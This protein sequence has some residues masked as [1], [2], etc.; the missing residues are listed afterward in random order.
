MGK[1]DDLIAAVGRAAPDPK[2]IRA[3]HG[4]PYDFDRFDASKIGSGEGAQAYGHGLYFAGEEGVAQYYRNKLA[5]QAPFESPD[6]VAAEYLKVWG[7]PS[8]VDWS[9]RKSP[10]L[11]LDKLRK[12][13]ADPGSYGYDA[14]QGKMLREAAELI[15]SGAPITPKERTGRM[16]EVA[17]Q[18][19]EES[20]LDYD[21]MAET[22]SPQVQQALRT[23]GF[24]AEP[25]LPPSRRFSAKV[26]MDRLGDSGGRR[27][28]ASALLDAGVPG[29]KYL[30]AASRGSPLG[31]RNYVMFPG[32]EDSIR[33][34]RK[35]GLLAPIAAS[36]M[37]ED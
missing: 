28:A 37:G 22:Q 11:A 9:S 10:A 29:V 34:L 20:L 32:T 13:A 2:Y 18:H 14:S 6:Q 16:Y 27:R 7:T 15:S 1:I 31:T 21:S 5:G 8:S 24:D 36:A 12:H 26:I 23:L 3:Y 25:G 17:I 35:Y 4:S 33:I 30:D 19:P